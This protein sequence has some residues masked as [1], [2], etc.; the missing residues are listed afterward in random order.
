MARRRQINIAKELKRTPPPPPPVREHVMPNG[1]K[2]VAWRGKAGKQHIFKIHPFESDDLGLHEASVVAA[3]RRGEGLPELVAVAVAMDP[4]EFEDWRRDASEE[5]A[6]EIH[7][8]MLTNKVWQAED[9][10][11]DLGFEPR[12]SPNFGMG[13]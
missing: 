3:V 7:V 4:E 13:F 1:V 10:V 5:G 6:N 9:L 12:R 11:E 8:H 2:F